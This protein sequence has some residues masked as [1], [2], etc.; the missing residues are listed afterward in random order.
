ME[1]LKELLSAEYDETPVMWECE[2][3][4]EIFNFEEE[5]GICPYCGHD[6]NP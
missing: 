1:L 5:D 3:C 6:N 4:G 2:N